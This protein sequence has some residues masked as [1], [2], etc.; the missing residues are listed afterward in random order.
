MRVGVI[1]LPEYRW[2]E[3]APR[4]READALGF[5]HAWTYDHLVWGGLVGAPWFGALPTLTAVATVTTRVRLGTFVTSPNFRHP[6]PFVRDLLTLDDVSGGR[7]IAGLGTGGDLDSRILGESLSVRDRVA[8]FH[9]FVPLVDRLLREDDVSHEGAWFTTVDAR[10]A[11]GPVQRPRVPLVVAANG[12]RSLRLAA[13]YGDG[14]VTSAH[15]RRETLESWWS[16][17]A[18]SAQRFDEAR[19]AVGEEAL[20]DPVD[21]HLALDAA[22]VYAFESADLFEELA[23]RAQELGFTDVIAPWPRAE[24]VYAGQESVVREVA[25]RLLT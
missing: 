19:E 12:P 15:G 21:R 5:H 8:R 3:A 22:P 1:I 24:G 23:G 25:S 6:Y 17:V 16:A 2:P 11:P 13:R 4:W 20:V 10:T 9:E 14:W 18:A 7:A